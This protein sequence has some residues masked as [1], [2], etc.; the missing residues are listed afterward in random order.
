MKRDRSRRSESPKRSGFKKQRQDPRE[1]TGQA[2]S[3]GLHPREQESPKNTR[4]LKRTSDPE[5]S[6]ERKPV[7]RHLSE[8]SNSGNERSRKSC[9]PQC[10][11]DDG[12]D[13]ENDANQPGQPSNL[14]VQPVN[15][16]T[17]ILPID[18][19]NDSEQTIDYRDVPLSE[20]E[21]EEH[22]DLFVS[23]D[24][25]HWKICSEEQKLTTNTS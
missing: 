16:P 19:D 4:M 8:N 12:T 6:R 17:P 25:I 13:V 11:E 2:S 18:G 7:K 20:E 21:P 5:T 22:E 3:S 1:R 10:D 14:P 9:K 24:D 23:L 15:E